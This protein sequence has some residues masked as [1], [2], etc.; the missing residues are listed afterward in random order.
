MHAI[1]SARIAARTG[2]ASAVSVR[3]AQ[4]YGVGR[5]IWA[6]E[7]RGTCH[8]ATSGEGCKEVWLLCGGQ[9]EGE[10]TTDGMRGVLSTRDKVQGRLELII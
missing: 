8:R 2:V 10:A 5:G 9:G 6:R 3:F 7:K 1:R 4:R